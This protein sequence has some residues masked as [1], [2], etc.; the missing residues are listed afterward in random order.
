MPN[1]IENAYKLSQNIYDDA[2]TQKKWWAKLYNYVFWGGVDNLEISKKILSIIPKDFSGV[3]LD[4]P[5]GT[6][7]FT[8]EKYAALPLSKIICLDYSEDMLVQAKSRFEK[9][10]ISN[11]QCIQGDVGNL[12]FENQMFDVCSPEIYKCLLELTMIEFQ[13]SLRHH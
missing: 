10:H 13:R 8:V 7:Q 3:L 1:K 6:A 11:V 9:H 12:P 2:L 4:V 5:V